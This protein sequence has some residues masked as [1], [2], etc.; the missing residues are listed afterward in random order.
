VIGPALA[1]ATATLAAGIALALIAGRIRSLKGRVVALALVA[2]ALPLAAVV[3]SGMLMFDSGH[4]LTVLAVA[5]ASAT[6]A[7][8][9]AFLVAR[10][11]L[12]PVGQVRRASEALAR[13]DLTA[14][15]PESGPAELAE[16]GATFNRMAGELERLFDARREL[17]AHASHDLRTPLA[18]L[19][20][21]LEAVEDG[22][23]PA[24]D[25]L[26]AM[27]DQVRHLGR[28]VDDLFELARIDAGQ[29]TLE[30]RDV[31]LDGLVAG[32]VSGVAASAE[33]R[34]VRVES[35]VDASA[36]A[37]RCAP[38]HL[39]RVLL[40]LLA[41]ALRHTPGDGSV[42]VLVSP[43]ADGVRLSVEDTGDGIPSGDLERAF[44]RFWRADSAR[45]RDGGGAGLGLAI[46]KGLVEA[47]GGRIWAE[48]RP[49]GGARISLVLPAA[50]AVR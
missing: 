11:V 48:A 14:R 26:P 19:Q 6:A 12:E 23:A 15:A 37:A 41:N 10:S 35:H 28:L 16:L 4:D 40:N 32:C 18:S 5:S 13:G 7:L 9:G 29:L 47:Q 3:A 8:V 45:R 30:L 33:A 42:A 1:V 43:E 21:M 25:Y 36:P 44:E 17:V 34:G 22:L 39:E 38:D 46:A 31:R 24:E 20:A 49:G 2:V 27:G 50:A